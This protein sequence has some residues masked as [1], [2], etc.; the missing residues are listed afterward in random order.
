MDRRS[1]DPEGVQP[2]RSGEAGAPPVSRRTLLRAGL[3]GGLLAAGGGALSFSGAL[4]AAK[5]EYVL[6]VD[7]NKCV[8][9]RVCESACNQ[10][11]RLPGEQ[12]YI[13]VLSRGDEQNRW[14]LPVQC[15]HCQHAPC[16]TV[17][18][19]NAT[20]EHSSGVVLV[21]E[22]T[23]VGCKYCVVAC[24]Y[25]ARIYDEHTGVA[26]KCWLCLDWVLGGGEPACV[27]ACLPGARVFGRRSDR[28][29]ARILASGRAQPLHPEFGTDPGVLLYI[30]PGT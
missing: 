17:C 16:A 23:C 8:G 14:F 21:N 12:S 5:S 3:A 22:K 18:P 19:V 29:I 11:N 9:C 1:Q 27:Q 26:S 13:R 15:Q 24:P 28:Q 20:Y 6:I 4:Q 25:G 2:I 7:L 30:F 10:R